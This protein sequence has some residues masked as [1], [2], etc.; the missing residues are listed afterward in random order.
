MKFTKM[1]GLGNDYVFVDCFEQRVTDPVALA[2]A[3][4][5]RHRGIGSDGL[6]LIRPSERADVRME[7][8]NADGSRA[9]MCGN[10]IRCVAKYAQEHGLLRGRQTAPGTPVGELVSKWRSSIRP[11]DPDDI[12]PVEV[13]S[14]AGVHALAAM[15]DRGSGKVTTVR[16]D[17]GPVSLRPADLPCTLGGERVVDQPVEFGGRPYRITCVSVGN[18]HVVV[19]VDDLASVRLADEG[20]LIETSAIFPKRTNVH[21]ARV[22]SRRRV[23]MISWERGSG[24]TQACGTGACAVGV[25]AVLVKNSQ[26]DLLVQLPGGELDISWQPNGHVHMTGSAVEVFTGAWP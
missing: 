20:R 22:L 26:R 13:E 12:V 5:D 18:P 15:V 7:M 8:Y 24:A 6:I 21:F 25:A 11:L 19:F 1:H 9:Q 17:M 2:R 16:V 23:R 10:G 14:D 3:V 4:S